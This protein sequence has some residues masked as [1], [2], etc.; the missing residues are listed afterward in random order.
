MTFSYD[1]TWADAMAMARA[2]RAILLTV[3]GTFL[4]LPQFALA[5]FAPWPEFKVFDQQALGVLFGYFQTSWPAILAATVASRF[6]EAVVLLLL[7]DRARPTVGQSLTSAGSLLLTYLVATYLVSAAEVAGGF[8]FI[9]PGIYVMGRL[10]LAA[11]AMLAEHITNPVRAVERSWQLTR[12]RGFLIAGLILLVAIVATVAGSA[13]A[14]A[15]TLLLALLIP[16]ELIP[17]IRALIGSM[18]GMAT[19]LI[20]LLLSAAAYRQLAPSRAI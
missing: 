13:L 17:L 6:G 2:N 9:V 14:E 18:L 10:F 8:L 15:V 12:G 16:P 5:L 3:A 7:L 11:P 4:F 20:M 19:S 1:R